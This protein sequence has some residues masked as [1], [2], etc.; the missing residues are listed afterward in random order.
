MARWRVRWIRADT[1]SEEVDASPSEDAARGG[2]GVGTG[3]ADPDLITVLSAM[4]LMM[5]AASGFDMPAAVRDQLKRLAQFIDQ[6]MAVDQT[7][8][9]VW[10]GL[11]GPTL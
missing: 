7:G 6:V 2:S 1:E 10:F 8:Q 9:T 11:I 5:T 3:P 4:K